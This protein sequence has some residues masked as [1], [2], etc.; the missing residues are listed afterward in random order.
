MHDNPGAA[1]HDG[2]PSQVSG[3]EGSEIHGLELFRHNVCL[4]SPPAPPRG[5]CD[6]VAG[7]RQRSILFHPA[8]VSPK[9]G[10]STSLFFRN[11]TSRD[12]RRD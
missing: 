10:L 12:I 6:Q 2:K 4:K 5:R 3:Q 7:P 8:V 1:G 9:R 11:P